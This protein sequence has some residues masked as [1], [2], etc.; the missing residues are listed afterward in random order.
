MNSLV[1]G[2]AAIIALGSATGAAWAA[3]PGALPPSQLPSTLQ[4]AQNL[5]NS[6]NNDPYSNPI[7][8]AN[9][10]SMQGTQPSNPGIRGPGTAPISRPPTLENGGIGNGYPRGGVQPPAPD[11][12]VHNPRDD[13]SNRR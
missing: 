4:L 9:P 5:P 13:D 11:P 7:R 6:G 12:R 8:R 1:R 10:N 3:N 2:L